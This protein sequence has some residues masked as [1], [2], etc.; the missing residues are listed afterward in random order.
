MSVGFFA[1]PVAHYG[2]LYCGGD[3]RLRLKATDESE[4]RAEL[5][6]WLGE[7]GLGPAPLYRVVGQFGCEVGYVRLDAEA[8]GSR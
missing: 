4:A 6:V 8:R 7:R 2:G 1:V 3:G 5:G